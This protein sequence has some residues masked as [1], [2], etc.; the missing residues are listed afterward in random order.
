MLKLH[1]LFNVQQIDNESNQRSVCIKT[2]N[3]RRTVASSMS[4]LMALFN[5]MTPTWMC[6]D[7]CTLWQQTNSLNEQVTTPTQ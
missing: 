6:P 1:L 2:L 4:Q 7:A 3:N 5:G